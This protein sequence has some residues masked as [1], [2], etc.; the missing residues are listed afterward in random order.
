MLASVPSIVW[1]L[2]EPEVKCGYIA[3]DGQNAISIFVMTNDDIGVTLCD[4][5]LQN[6][7]KT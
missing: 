3:T 6:Y 2:H 7:G 4:N 1:A 5:Y